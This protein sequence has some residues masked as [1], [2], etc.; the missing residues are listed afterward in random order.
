MDSSIISVLF[1][2]LVERKDLFSSIKINDYLPHCTS[3][4]LIV[5]LLYLMCQIAFDISIDENII[6]II[7]IIPSDG[8][9]IDIMAPSTLCW[10][11]CICGQLFLSFNRNYIQDTQ[12]AT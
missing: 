8:Y 4:D 2:A 6:P 10:T 9:F 7:E 1:V 3:K 12:V 5:K 11:G